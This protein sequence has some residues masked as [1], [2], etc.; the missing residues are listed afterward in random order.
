MFMSKKVFYYCLIVNFT[1]LK[2]LC[3]NRCGVIK[4]RSYRTKEEVPWKDILE[5]LYWCLGVQVR[6]TRHQFE[7]GDLQALS[8]MVPQLRQRSACV[9]RLRRFWGCRGVTK[10]ERE[11]TALLDEIDKT[12]NTDILDNPTQTC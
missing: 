2:I 3:F 11:A 1:K 9:A 4:M 6:H 12:E 10:W 7:R 8:P 5:M